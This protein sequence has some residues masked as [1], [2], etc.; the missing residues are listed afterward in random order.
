VGALSLVLG[1]SSRSAQAR[2]AETVRNWAAAN[3]SQPQ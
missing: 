2:A 3:C 1:L